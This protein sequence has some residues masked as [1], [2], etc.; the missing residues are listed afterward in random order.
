MTF[1]VCD[2]TEPLASAKRM[3]DAG[4]SVVFAPEEAGGS[5]VM[6]LESREDETLIEED[7]TYYME[8]WIT[9]PEALL[10]FAKQP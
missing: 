7:G 4:H 1:Q 3:M 2:V 9:P 10:G 6:S 5:F 8:L